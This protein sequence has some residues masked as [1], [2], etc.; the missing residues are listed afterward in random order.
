MGREIKFRAWEPLN[1]KVVYFDGIAPFKLSDRHIQLALST[2]NQGKIVYTSM[3][4][5]AI[6][7][8][9]FTGLKD[10]NGVDIYEGDIVAFE[11]RDDANGDLPA[12]V[13]Y[14]QFGNGSFYIKRIISSH[15]RWMDYKTEIIGNIYE[16]PHL[17]AKEV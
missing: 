15:Y 9:Q 17:L 12:R 7:L 4:L 5:N 11:D 6:N 14:V 1:R 3:N 16:H 8:M 13:G 10:K 2:D